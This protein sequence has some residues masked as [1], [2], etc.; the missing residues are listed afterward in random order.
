MDFVDNK[1]LMTIVGAILSVCALPFFRHLYLK[2]IEN[3]PSVFFEVFDKTFTDLNE[4][5]NIANILQKGGVLST[6]RIKY[7]HE[8]MFQSMAF[9]SGTYRD[10]D[11]I[12]IMPTNNPSNAEIEVGTVVV[13]NSQI[14]SAVKESKVL[15]KKEISI[16]LEKNIKM[17][18]KWVKQSSKLNEKSKVDLASRFHTYFMIIH[19]FVDGN[20]RLGRRLLSEQLSYIF[21]K[22]IEFKPASK[23]YYDSINKAS[24]GDETL[25]K[26]LIT[27]SLAENSST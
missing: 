21:G 8:I 18:N 22:H 23:T 16:A 25:L 17:W 9:Q 26:Q 2:Y 24:S 1:Q 27:N 20:G 12:I 7:A 3:K 14:G 11:V 4:Q 13:S 10:S 19:P 15:Y 6:K 5:L